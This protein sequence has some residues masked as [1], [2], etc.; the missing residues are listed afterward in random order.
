MGKLRSLQTFAIDA[1]FDAIL[2]SPTFRK[3]EELLK[4]EEVE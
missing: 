3:I 1:I 2:N 4:N